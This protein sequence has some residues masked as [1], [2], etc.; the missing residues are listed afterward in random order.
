MGREVYGGD[1]NGNPVQVRLYDRGV[2]AGALGLMLNSVV[3][4]FTSLGVEVLARAVGGVKRLWE[5]S[6]PWGRRH[7]S[8]PPPGDVK[9]GA[10]ALFAVMGVP[11][12]IT[13]SIPLLW[14]Q[15]F[16]TLL[17]LVK[18]VVSVVSGPWDALFGGGNLPA[19]VVGGVA[20][21]ASGIFAFTLLPSPQP[22]AP[23]PRLQGLSLLPSIDLHHL[24]VYAEM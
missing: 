1:S 14:H 11:Q 17:V 2:R 20:A 18:M 24:H 15:Y 10:L 8:L 12:A 13:Y 3:L 16:V 23:P 22:D 4:G 9:A 7:G 19:F 6:P 5:G 21:A